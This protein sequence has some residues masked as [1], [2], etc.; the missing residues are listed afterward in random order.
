VVPRQRER[1]RERERE[2]EI[3]KEKEVLVWYNTID[4][5]FT[6]KTRTE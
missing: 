3:R 1:G 2:R 4:V 5:A 6:S